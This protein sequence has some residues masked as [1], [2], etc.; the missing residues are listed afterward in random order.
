MK[1]ILFCF[2]LLT[3]VC[4][5]DTENSKIRRA[6]RG[7][8]N[9]ALVAGY[10]LKEFEILET[11]LDINLKDSITHY[12]AD[13]ETNKYF[14]RTDSV[15]L[16]SIMSNIE[17]CKLAKRQTLYHLRSTYDGLIRDY[18]KMK[19]EIEN[20]IASR[21]KENEISTK[22]IQR[23]KTAMDNSESP[24]IYYK[25]KHI[26][27]INGLRKEEIVILDNQYNFIKL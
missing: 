14:I 3:M 1:K 16:N 2:V 6:L 5:C 20:R 10:Q 21:N 17:D 12:Y 26:Y 11:I 15:Q 7:S 19:D 9:P 25:L 23:Y 27:E 24:I 4:S 13:I 22:K 18:E 8:V